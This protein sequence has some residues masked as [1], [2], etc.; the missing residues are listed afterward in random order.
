[1]PVVEELAKDEARAGSGLSIEQARDALRE[2]DLP[3]EKLEGA[4]AKVRE[5]REAEALAKSKYGGRCCSAPA[6]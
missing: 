4:A 6:P 3:P 2:L 5:R 1:M